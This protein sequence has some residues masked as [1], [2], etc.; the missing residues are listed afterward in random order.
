MPSSWLTQVAKRL[1]TK[2]YIPL[3]L[4]QWIRFE[5]H[6]L[7]VRWN[8]WL[9]PLQIWRRRKLRC[10]NQVKLH[11]GC[12]KNV[13]DDWV[14]I[15][16]WKALGID[17][18]MD[19][20]C[21]LPFSNETVLRIFTEHVLEHFELETATTILSEFH[22]VLVP[23]GVV[24][25]VVPD[26]QLYCSAYVRADQKWFEQA[27]PNLPMLNQGINALFS[28]SSHKHIYDFD[29]LA[30]LLK[31]VGF[32]NIVKSHFLGSRHK[33]LQIDNDHPMRYE[34]SL[35]VEAEK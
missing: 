8:N 1:V 20:R 32:S 3:P 23:G 7:R 11:W 9:N 21:K 33:E 17:Y 5:I 6:L 2:T 4:V 15:D 26:I 34:T 22:R 29:T 13:L 12:G 28:D 24:R 25:I 14:N 27:N 31:D 35:Y 30:T 10:I 18:V 19:L 16:G